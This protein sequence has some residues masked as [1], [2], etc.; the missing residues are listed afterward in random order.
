MKLRDLEVGKKFRLA[1]DNGKI[2]QKLSDNGGI[3]TYNSCK[4]LTSAN[5]L[6]MDIVGLS[7]RK[8]DR[9]TEVSP[10]D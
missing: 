2:Y 10:L 5:P 9:N 8:I 6:R 3:A 4:C 1:N 7:N